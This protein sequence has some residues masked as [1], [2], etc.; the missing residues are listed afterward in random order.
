MLSSA[1]KWTSKLDAA[2]QDFH[3]LI[4]L[5]KREARP[6]LRDHHQR[7][8]SLEKFKA[9]SSCFTTILMDISMPVMNGFESSRAIR[10]HGRGVKEMKGHEAEVPDVRIIALMGLGSE[11]PKQEAEMSGTDVSY[12]E[13]V[14]FDALKDFLVK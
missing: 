11:A 3:S 2:S 10:S 9:A 8:R 14:N 6:H 7:P 13:P 1:N 5:S 12:T 4:P